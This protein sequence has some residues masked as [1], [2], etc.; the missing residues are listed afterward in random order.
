MNPP[1][2]PPV[3]EAGAVDAG[4]GGGEGEGEGEGEEPIIEDVP[5]DGEGSGRSSQ[6][7]NGVAVSE[8]AAAADEDESSKVPLPGPWEWTTAEELDAVPDHDPN[9]GKGA[10]GGEDENGKD[11]S[12][13]K[14]DPVRLT[15][16]ARLRPTPH[17]RTHTLMRSYTHILHYDTITLSHAHTHTLA[18]S[19]RLSEFRS[20][21]DA[22]DA[23]LF[24]ADAKRGVCGVRGRRRRREGWK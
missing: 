22:E 5:K 8:P 1:A 14:P 11:G 2:P 24:R 6:P 9:K 18:N 21:E 13:D 16:L 4:T 20:V 17:A 15:P 7:P 19:Y 3:V 12:S 10:V 23:Q